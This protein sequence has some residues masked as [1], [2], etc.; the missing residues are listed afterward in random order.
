VFG[1]FQPLAPQYAAAEGEFVP[2]GYYHWLRTWVNDFKYVGPT[3]WDLELYRIDVSK[4]PA[5]A[6]TDD[7]ERARVTAL[8]DQYNNS[9]PDH[10]LVPKKASA[11]SDDNDDNSADSDSSDD[12]NDDSAD[13]NDDQDHDQD[14]DEANGELNLKITPDVDAQFEEI[15][16]Q[17]IKNEPARYYIVLPAE[18]AVTMWFD[19]HA[20][21]YPFTGA[22]LPLTD[23]DTDIHQDIWLPLFFAIDL[24]YTLIAI[25]GIL[26][27][28]FGRWPRSR[29]WVLMA[30]L[31][32]VPRIAFFSTL[33]NP[34]P[35]YLIELFFI[36]AVLGGI[37][38]SR[39][40]F[41]RGSGKVGLTITYGKDRSKP[42]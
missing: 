40:Q 11:D 16:E 32:A 7:A 2:K 39:I 8:I 6:F 27:L 20:D 28:W 18:R 35:R 26:L 34:E 33:E 15:A 38:L 36:A 12:N 30:L 41:I 4:L 19:N 17:R 13:D 5:S 37:A 23:L 10:P 1:Q 22:L 25:V 9:D 42:A 31:M 14:S 21:F 24:V 3:Q 29:V